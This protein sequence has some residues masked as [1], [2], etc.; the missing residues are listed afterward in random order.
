MLYHFIASYDLK[1]DQVGAETLSLNRINFI[2]VNF[3]TSNLPWQDNPVLPTDWTIA[4]DE[5]M[6]YKNYIFSHFKLPKITVKAE[7]HLNLF[8]ARSTLNYLLRR[9]FPE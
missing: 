6:K 8:L 1:T 9:G 4:H 3:K 5:F 2:S 7:Q